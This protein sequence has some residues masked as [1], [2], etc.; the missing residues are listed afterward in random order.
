[1]RE[2]VVRGH[3]E[4]LALLLAPGGVGLLVTDVS[5]SEMAPLTSLAR[6][7]PPA[8]LLAALTLNGRVFPALAPH[9]IQHVLRED[10][11]FAPRVEC[12]RLEPPWLWRALPDRDYLVVAHRFRRRRE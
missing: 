10:P 2:H 3:L 12:V 7:L 6:A 9:E 5:S 8:T 1:V 4:L 11:C